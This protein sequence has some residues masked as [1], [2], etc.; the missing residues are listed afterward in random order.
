MVEFRVVASPTLKSV[1]KNKKDKRQR[2]RL[3]VRIYISG[4]LKHR[5]NYYLN[6]YSQPIYIFRTDLKNGIVLNHEK[7][8]R[9]T[10]LISFSKKA[11][12]EI[13]KKELDNKYSLNI[14]HVKE[15][16]G[17]YIV[18]N[19]DIDFS[20]SINKQ[21][22]TFKGSGLNNYDDI[23]V[24][25]RAIE[26]VNQYNYPT[27]PTVDPEGN[28]DLA[29]FD[30][31]DIESAIIHEDIK[32]TQEAE[33]IRI[34]KLSTEIRYKKG[35]YT[36]TNIFELFAS[37]Y[38]DDSFAG[39]YDKIVIR[40]FEYR[41]YRKPQESTSYFNENWITKFFKYLW[42]QG[43]TVLNTQIFDPIKFDPEIFT[44]KR[45]LKYSVDNFYKLF[46]IVKT[47]SN[48]FIK[49]GLLNKISFD[50]IDL[51]AIC[52]E[53]KSKKG[54]RV[55]HNLSNDEFNKLFFF[56][57]EEKLIDQYQNI[58]EGIYDNRNIKLNLIHLRTARDM[59][60]LQI[61]SGGLR[62]YKEL[63]TLQFN[64]NDSQLSFH[65]EKID[66]WMINPFNTYTEIIAR[67]YDHNL[68]QLGFNYSQNT[69]EH[70]YRALLKTIAE[71]VSFDR[72]II[73]RNK[74]VKIK[75]LFNP[76]FARK[77]FSQIMYDEYDF[78]LENIAMFTGHSFESG[79]KSVLLKN[80][81]D[82]ESPEKK[83][84]LFKKIKLP[85]GFTKKTTRF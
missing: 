65:M 18:T 76:Y 74:R 35:L 26:A 5:F 34:S 4:I 22:V 55:K 38:Y 69:L 28:V 53:K 9:Y 57:F 48:K 71:I 2:L 58:F 81:I 59:F 43:Y 40:L 82:T 36:K 30:A 62:G 25:K 70:I 15:L 16:V 75:S 73:Y 37:I 11:F 46:D 84:K 6:D 39:T 27:E 17:N 13:V 77:T 19:F 67:D 21:L 3:S 85:K 52:G 24:D 61:M 83:K 45:I 32:L 33:K 51:Y 50:D 60:C 29:D 80:Y 64:R 23:T 49:L 72:E 63:Q 44:N 68:P 78:T 14:T 1:D 41:H 79:Q 54:K 12:E 31:G 56:K 10:S 66:Y 47:V 42:E 7:S 20:E 8:I